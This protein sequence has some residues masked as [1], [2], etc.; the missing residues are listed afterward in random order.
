ME[1]LD[2]L[3]VLDLTRRYPGSYCAMFLGDNGAD[4]IKVDPPLRTL[5][6]KR[7][8]IAEARYAAFN[9]QDRNKR[10]IVL[11]LKAESSREVF[12]RLVKKADVLVEGFRPGVMDRLGV[13]YAC[14]KEVNPRLIYTALS[15]FGQDGP[16]AHMPA[17]DMNYIAIGGALS[18]IGERNGQPYLPSNIVADYAG[19]GL[20]GVIGTLLALMARER[21]GRGQFVDIS[22]VDSVISLLAGNTWSYFESGVVPKRGETQA[23]GGQPWAQVFRCKDGE[24]L[25]IAPAE[26]PFWANL[27]RA[28]GREDLIPQQHPKTLDESDRI[29]DQLAAIFLTRTRDDWW[30]YLKDKECCVGPVLTADETFQHPQ[31][32]HRKMLLEFDDPVHGQVRQMGIPIKLSDT[33]GA[34]RHLGVPTGTDTVAVLQE[35]GYSDSEI[36]R[37]REQRA[38]E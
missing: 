33:P 38:F 9:P 11:N 32:L 12:L 23:T 20:H 34:V 5:R 27:C 36:A 29:R 13:G 16:Y 24:Y 25:T 31:V 1:A 22:Y 7:A 19:A 17:H 30:E 28:L 4:V 37:L 8:G 26:D 21:T 14:L 10:S 15:G 2:G 18:L 6:I 3:V 35:L